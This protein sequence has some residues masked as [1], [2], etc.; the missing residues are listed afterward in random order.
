ML[1]M[2]EPSNA[3]SLLHQLNSDKH[4]VNMSLCLEFAIVRTRQVV[5]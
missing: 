4:T 1:F 2:P 5:E 3:K